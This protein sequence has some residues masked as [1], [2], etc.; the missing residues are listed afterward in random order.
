MLSLA[1]RSISDSFSLRELSF[2]IRLHR[3]QAFL[4][5]FLSWQTKDSTSTRA[6]VSEE[7]VIQSLI[8]ETKEYLSAICAR[9]SYHLHIVREAVVEELKIAPDGNSVSSRDH[10]YIQQSTTTESMCNLLH[11]MCLQNKM[12]CRQRIMGCPSVYNRAE[13]IGDDINERSRKDK[14]MECWESHHGKKRSD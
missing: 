11:K 1:F 14:E 8:T 4:L 3:F 5:S 9:A 10:F 6:E 7:A 12:D 13:N 2:S